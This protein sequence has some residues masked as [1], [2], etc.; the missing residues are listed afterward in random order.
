MLLV[1]F[2]L[3]P[4]GNVPFVFVEVWEEG[5]CLLWRIMYLC[6]AK[7]VGK[8][9]SLGIDACTANDIYFLLCRTTCEGLG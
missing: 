5:I 3:F 1:G 6:Q 9:Q 2:V 8:G 7:A 4:E